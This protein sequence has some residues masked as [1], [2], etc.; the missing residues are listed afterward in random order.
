MSFLFIFP[1][2]R[3][4]QDNYLLLGACLFGLMATNV[5][6]GGLVPKFLYDYFPLEVR[7]LGTGLIYNLAATS[8]TFNSMGGDLAWNNNGA[9]RCA[10]VHCCFLDR[11]N[12]THYWPIPFRDRLK[13]RRESFQSTKEFLIEDK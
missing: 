10:N 8:G 1:L 11:N 7:G 4:P 13:A 6:V 5:G 9:R 3:I 2:F 12:S